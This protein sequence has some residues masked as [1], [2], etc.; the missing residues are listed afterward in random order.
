MD[1]G[2]HYINRLIAAGIIGGLILLAILWYP[3][4][5][6]LPGLYIPEL[7]SGAAANPIIFLILS[8]ITLIAT[9]FAAVRLSRAGTR[10]GGALRGAAAASIGA[11]LVYLLIGGA[12]AG[13]VGSESMLLHGLQPAATDTEATVLLMKSVLDVAQWTSLSLLAVLGLGAVS[14]AVGGSFVKPS[15]EVDSR[16][17]RRHWFT[18]IALTNYFGAIPTVFLTTIIFILL[19]EAISNISTD[20][21]LG[22][23]QM[24]INSVFTLPYLA[25]MIPYLVLT[26]FMAWMMRAEY[27]A[28]NPVFWSRRPLMH[29]IMLFTGAVLAT[30]AP[31]AAGI[32]I[33][34][35]LAI[36][37]ALVSAVPV[38][39]FIYYAIRQRAS[40]VANEQAARLTQGERIALGLYTVA[41]L[42]WLSSSPPIIL[43]LGIVAP[44][45]GFFIARRSRQ[46]SLE[47]GKADGFAASFYAGRS[48]LPTTIALISLIALMFIPMALTLILIQVVMIPTLFA[49]DGNPEILM[50]MP[51]II[52]SLYQA[53]PGTVV[54]MTI[55][56]SVLSSIVLGIFWLIHRYK[57]DADR[58]REKTVTVDSATDGFVINPNVERLEDGD[59]KILSKD[60]LPDNATSQTATSF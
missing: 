58:F 37:A 15:E 26:S 33:G 49:T 11:L 19:P 51:Q 45:A 21:N 14:G 56:V 27:H 3:L 30:A 40:L 46:E 50:T 20:N 13:I 38:I 59:T 32:G 60:M 18:P 52:Q 8:I 17:E 9:G 53:V 10:L 4:T 16:A 22:L 42:A 29:A 7:A 41:A 34:S 55:L 57:L 43:L 28:G 35:P 5:Q 31:L 44:I 36:I 48:T 39:A 12:A 6:V 2:N 54:T 1:K 25:T 23:S 47:K 24:T